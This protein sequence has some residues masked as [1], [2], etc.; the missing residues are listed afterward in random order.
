MKR[1][2]RKLVMVFF[3]ILTLLYGS[4]VLADE[5]LSYNKNL[6]TVVVN[7]P[8]GAKL[9][10][11]EWSNEKQADEL[12]EK[13]VLSS[14]SLFTVD[15]TFEEDGKTYLATTLDSVAGIKEAILASDV[16]IYGEPVSPSDLRI[17]RWQKSYS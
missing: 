12:V 5:T 9:Y 7:N 17:R 1:L 11:I 13:K 10:S 14:G 4:N 3:M 8:D 16:E 6:Y 2:L 15:F